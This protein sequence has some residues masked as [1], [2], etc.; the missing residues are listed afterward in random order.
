[1]SN[2]TEAQPSGSGPEVEMSVADQSRT[3]TAH[4]TSPRFQIRTDAETGDDPIDE[5]RLA[6]AMATAKSIADL[7]DRSLAVNRR[8]QLAYL[9]NSLPV[10]WERMTTMQGHG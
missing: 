7:T 3:Q 2:L 10:L 8:T 6:E 5:N 9:A 1:M 4:G